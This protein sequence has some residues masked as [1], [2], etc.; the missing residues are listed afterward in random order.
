MYFFYFNLLNFICNCCCYLDSK[1]KLNRYFRV[2]KKNENY[3]GGSYYCIKMNM[4]TLYYFIL[5]LFA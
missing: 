3:P 4:F 2:A 5:F 1:Q